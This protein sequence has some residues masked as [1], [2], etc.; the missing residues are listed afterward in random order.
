MIHLYDYKCLCPYSSQKTE[1]LFP[2]ACM[3][4]LKYDSVYSFN[5]RELTLE[6]RVQPASKGRIRTWGNNKSG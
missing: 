3:K 5:P 2:D 1:K 6:S 4:H